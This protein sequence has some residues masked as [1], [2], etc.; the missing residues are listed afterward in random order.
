MDIA[1]GEGAVVSSSDE[2]EEFEFKESKPKPKFDF[3]I[4][5]ALYCVYSGMYVL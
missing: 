3:D 2:E 1:R 4:S 5:G